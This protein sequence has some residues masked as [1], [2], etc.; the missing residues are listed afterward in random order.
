[1]SVLREP[2]FRRLLIGETVSGFGD[3]ALFL[4]LAVWARDLT[5]S[6][7]AAGLVF[8]FL[9]VPG[10]ASPLLGHLVDRARRKPLL[11]SLYAGMALFVLSLLAVR[12]ADDLWLI[13]LAAAAY[14]FMAVI[15]AR[16]ALL[17]DLLP[18]AAAAEARSWLIATREGARVVSPA[19]G[20]WI[21]VTYGPEVLVLLDSATF[22]VAVV[23]LAGVRV[24]ESPP[25]AR[26]GE[27]LGRRLMA[28][29]A[30]VRSVRLL[31]RLAGTLVAFM[32]VVGVMET[33]VFSAIDE[34]L[35]RPAEFFGVVA[36]VQGAGSAVAGLG[37]IV[38]IRRLGELGTAAVAYGLLAAGMLL[39]AFPSLPVFLGGV[40]L[41]GMG[42]PLIAVSLGT[43]EHLYTPSRLQGR[44]GAA[45]GMVTDGAQ[46]MSIAAGAALIGVVDHRVMYAAIA[47]V[48]LSCAL[49][50]T[51]R[52]PP[53][54]AVVPSL[55]DTPAEER[56][57][58]T[59]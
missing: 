9:T 55:A 51:V 26:G 11:I 33:A 37:A 24:T 17:K 34:G 1:M 14:G 2:R 16:N 5:G 41:I 59:A 7:A 40:V 23:A 48:S 54:P 18:S 38:L 52:R 22:V 10:L 44:V 39:C 43:A 31:R 30:H 36:S 58:P 35:G 57:A 49:A 28:G 6:D 45:V 13:Y 25:E 56:S 46:S 20:T 15:P 8:L 21:Y 50:V 29:F 4:A 3:S 12:S 47:A 32:A 27:P 19:A 53:A 42:V